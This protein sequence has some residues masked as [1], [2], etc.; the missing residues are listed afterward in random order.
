MPLVFK[1]CLI[2]GESASINLVLTTGCQGAADGTDDATG[3][4]IVAILIV[5]NTVAGNQVGLILDGT[6]PGENLKSILA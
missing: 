1:I 4:S 2:E 5:A 6:G 3:T